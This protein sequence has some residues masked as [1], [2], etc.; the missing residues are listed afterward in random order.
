M[1]MSCWRAF[2]DTP[3]SIFV[4][5]AVKP[6]RPVPSGVLRR[7]PHGFDAAAYLQA[8]PDV[9]AAGAEP[10]EHY[11]RFGWAEGRMLA[12]NWRLDGIRLILT[13]TP[14]RSGTTYLSE[15]LKAVSGIYSDHNEPK[16]SDVMRSA[17]YDT[18][19]ACRFLLS[20]SFPRSDAA[21]E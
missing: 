11:R 16:F 19:I 5:R 12:P 21:L 20:Q 6:P 8:N 2:L 4:G 14:G 13:I 10:D 3:R 15:L 1:T 9:A 18:Q 17:Q 7:L